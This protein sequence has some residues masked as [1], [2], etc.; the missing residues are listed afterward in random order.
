MNKKVMEKELREL[1]S[2]LTEG[3]REDVRSTKKKIDKF[4][5]K[6]HKAFMQTAPV[7]LEYLSKFDQV[8]KVENQAA[9]AS[10]LSLFF[11]VLADEY[12]NRLADF[13]L[14]VMQ[15]P[16]GT[17]R[18][19]IR[20]SADWLYISLTARAEPFVYPRGKKLTEEQKAAQ[21]QAKI[22]YVKLVKEIEILIDRYNEE[23]ERI[24]YINE[25]KPSVNK[26]LQ[27]FWSRLT[28]SRTYQRIIAEMRPLPYEIVKKRKEIESEISTMLKTNG[29]D[30]C[31]EDIKD[32]I[33][34]EDGS[35]SLTDI[36]TMF[37]KGQ[38]LS[39][40]ENVLELVNEAWNYFPHKLLD[41]LSPAE[42]SLEY[43]QTQLK[44]QSRSN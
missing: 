10:G 33:Y 13:T 7:V 15:H 25:M 29:S 4:W 30:F 26:S 23:D 6:D 14:Q 8:R 40:L 24:Q 2:V 1:L 18:E 37:D 3:N 41:G 35:D 27:L 28:E 42:K 31:L 11:L 43:Q 32:I 16:N 44:N 17:I 9:F 34:Y 5:H 12:F 36:I 22:Q 19:A 38:G 21:I 39:E 20:K